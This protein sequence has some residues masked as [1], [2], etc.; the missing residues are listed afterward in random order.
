MRIGI[1]YDFHRLVEGRTL[2]LGGVE[3]PHDKG[4]LGHSDGDALTHAICDA[5]LG[6]MAEADIGFHFPPTDESIRG[7][8]S[9]KILSFVIDIMKRRRF[10]IVNIDAIVIAEEPRIIHYREAIRKNLSHIMGISKGMVNVKGKT[11]EGLGA[12]GAKEGIAAHAVAVLEI[13]QEP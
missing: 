9:E 7:I 11:A 12:I 8:S 6:A 10:R 1:G 3:I 13:S 2:Y 4:L 5:I